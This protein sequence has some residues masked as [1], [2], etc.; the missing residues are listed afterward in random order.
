MRKHT[1]SFVHS[2]AGMEGLPFDPIDYSHLKFGSD[3]V[4]KKFG[5]EIAETFFKDHSEELLSNRVVVFPSPYN[6]VENAASV[7][8]RHMIDRLNHLLVNAN[9]NNVEQS[10][11][12]RKVSYTSDYGFLPKEKRRALIDNDEFYINKDFIKGKTLVFVDDVFITGTHEEK[13][14]E[15]LDVHGLNN[16]AYFL[17]YA[18]YAKGAVGAD[19][20]AAINFAG[21]RDLKDFAELT[22]RPGHNLIVRPIKYLLSRMPHEL[23]TCLEIFDVEFLT[24]VYYGA[25]GEGY[26]KI[27]NYQ[28]NFRAI[29]LRIGQSGGE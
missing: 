27:P 13:L 24:K 9:G 12:H 19:I 1:Q 7:M 26:H 23:A 2:F 5:Y 17:Y 15:I 22:K 10:L 16:P 18:K 8:T 25:I 29:M 4:A 28:D 20:E 3:E 14:V 6:H 11:I 21:I